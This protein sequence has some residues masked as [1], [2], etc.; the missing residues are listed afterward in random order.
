M[1]DS[2]IGSITVILLS[3]CG[4]F[5]AGLQGLGK[6]RGDQHWGR[7]S[8]MRVKCLGET[9]IP[10]LPVCGVI[11]PIGNGNSLQP[12]LHTLCLPSPQSQ[13]Q[14]LNP[15]PL[16]VDLE[17]WS[18]GWSWCPCLES[19]PCLLLHSCLLHFHLQQGADQIRLFPSSCHQPNVLKC[20]L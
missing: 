5:A 19:K 17:G 4:L 16:W 2:T 12:N 8:P 10:T 9:G 20:L 1:A 3:E 14:P 6:G 18:V 15:D 13:P 7:E 11:W